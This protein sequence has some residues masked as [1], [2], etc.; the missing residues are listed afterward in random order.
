MR[1]TSPSTFPTPL[2]RS[3]PTYERPPARALVAARQNVA[4]LSG[5]VPDGTTRDPTDASGAQLEANSARWPSTALRRTKMG[6]ALR[7]KTEELL[8]LAASFERR[9]PRI[10]ETPRSCHRSPRS[11]RSPC[12]HG[13][14][15]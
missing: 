5:E 12:V 9:A 15:R 8:H 3:R 14:P 10:E 2:A 4:Q 1:S 7:P 11:P 13:S 6:V